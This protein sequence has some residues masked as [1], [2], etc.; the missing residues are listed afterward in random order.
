MAETAAQGDMYQVRVKGFI[1]EQETNNV[2]H[3]TCAT[4]DTDV[5]LHL[6]LVL[7]QCY[8]TH[9]L[10][11]LSSAWI[12]D[13]VVWKRVSPTLGPEF[14]TAF[15]PA[16][17]GEIAG[18]SLPTYCAGLVSIR[19]ALGGRSHRGRM[20]LAGFGEASTTGSRFNTAH[21]TWPAILAFL[22]CLITKFVVGEP[23]G[24]AQ[25][26]LGVYSRKI[27]GSSFPY[28]APGFTPVNALNPSTLLATMRSRKVGRGT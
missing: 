18:D 3:F 10:P 1:E 20:Y 16:S 8:V 13:T 19:T 23:L 22:E 26:R 21:P 17:V 11:G 12:G 7:I 5:D 4:A 6:I 2:L 25:W 15:P 28:G 14:V 9:L 24:T 27:G